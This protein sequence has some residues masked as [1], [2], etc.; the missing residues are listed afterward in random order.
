M[1]P[2]PGTDS[3]ATSAPLASG[4]S[5]L[6]GTEDKPAGFSPEKQNTH[7]MA[8]CFYEVID[9]CSAAVRIIIVYLP[10]QSGGEGAERKRAQAYK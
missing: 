9:R 10:W 6:A 8:T 4:T 5:H 7:L 3:R 2:V 1:Q